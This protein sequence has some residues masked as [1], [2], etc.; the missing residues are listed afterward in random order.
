MKNLIKIAGSL[1]LLTSLPL[2]ALAAGDGWLCQDQAEQVLQRLQTEVVGELDP[3]QRASANQIVI[4]VCQ[5]REN[6]VE[7]QVEQAVQQVREEEQE[8]ANA[9][10]TESADKPGNRRLKRKSH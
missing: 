6:Q 2:A 9:W 4:D 5:V 8:Q 3:V 10:L 1:P 7:A